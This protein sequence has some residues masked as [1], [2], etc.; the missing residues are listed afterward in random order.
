MAIILDGNIGNEIAQI[1][2][3]LSEKYAVPLE[4]LGML[5][6]FEY[7]QHLKV[8][9]LMAENETKINTLKRIATEFLEYTLITGPGKCLSVILSI[10][11]QKYGPRYE[12]GCDYTIFS[13]DPILIGKKRNI[14]ERL[15][16]RKEK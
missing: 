5:I 12:F 16:N 14:L 7:G 15:L 4:Q 6:Q 3:K 9:N 2:N 13:K 10:D 11:P 8:N 1:A